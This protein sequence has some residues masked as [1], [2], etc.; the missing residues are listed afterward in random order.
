MTA[1]WGRGLATIA[2]DGAVL[3]TWY[4]EVGL[5]GETAPD[6]FAEYLAAERRDEARGVT[7][8]AVRTSIDTQD[9]P[10]D[11]HDAYLRLHLLS[12][13]LVRPREQN[14]DGVFG[15]LV[16]VAWTNLEIGRAHV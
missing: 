15:L 13:R 8:R 6:T 10:A 2:D 16:N 11:A 5:G 12:H 4:R 7:I 9:K 1:A 3:D 14:L